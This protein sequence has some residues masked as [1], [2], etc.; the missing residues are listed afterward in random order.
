MRLATKVAAALI[1]AAAVLGGGLGAALG[2]AICL[3][4]VSVTTGQKLDAS[5]EVALAAPV[6]NGSEF[7][8]TETIKG[9]ASPGAVVEA[10]ADRTNAPMPQGGKLYLIARNGLSGR[11]ANFGTVE[12]EN[13][14]WLR[15]LL[16]TNDGQP[17]DPPRAW[18]LA[19]LVQAVPDSTNWS[20]RIVLIAPYLQSDDPLIAEIA[21]G[22]I[23]RAPYAAIR[24]LGPALDAGKLRRWIDDPALAQRRDAYILLLGI[25]GGSDDAATLEQ[26]L[27][28]ARTSRDAKNVAA[29]LAADLEL[30]GPSR[31]AW[32][33]ENYLLDHARSL[34]EIEAALLALNVHGGANGVVPRQQVVDAYRKFIRARQPM[35]GFVATYLSDWKAWDAVPDYMD[36]LRS[37]A[38]KDPASQ[39]AILVYLRDSPDAAAHSAAAALTAQQN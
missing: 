35:A 11:W 27:A 37:N 28:E 39:F 30:R 32:I 34:P 38:V 6:S 1:G 25:A 4:A 36:V 31:I 23:S 5:D 18:P 15:G 13:I 24:T 10:I 16:K 20:E 17:K 8:I 29:M 19:G 7:K 12:A 3:S 2:C 33:E 9:D 22:E 14:T 21:F 26:R